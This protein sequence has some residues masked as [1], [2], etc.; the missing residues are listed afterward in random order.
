M[1][2]ETTYEPIE[3]YTI[4]IEPT[5]PGMNSGSPNFVNLVHGKSGHYSGKVNLTMSGRW[6]IKLKLFKNGVLL[7]D[8]Q[9][10]EII[11]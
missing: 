7:S 4:E 8:D 1:I 3:D 2:N 6:Q 10:F 11:L 5:M 9:Y